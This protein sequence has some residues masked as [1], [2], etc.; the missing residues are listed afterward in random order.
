M[1]GPG[2]RPAEKPTADYRPLDL[3]HHQLPTV[4]QP[5]ALRAVFPSSQTL[6]RY[7][8]PGGEKRIFFTRS[9]ERPEELAEGPE[10]VHSLGACRSEKT[11]LGVMIAALIIEPSDRC[12]GWQ[13]HCGHDA[14]CLSHESPSPA[15]VTTD[16]A[17]VVDSKRSL[18][19]LA[20]L[21]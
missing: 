1:T 6:P 3:A 20:R 12:D 15:C 18:R 4:G 2:P 13:S 7:H 14:P 21:R 10:Y 11:T 19:I 8:R 16:S 17:S 9:E 5:A